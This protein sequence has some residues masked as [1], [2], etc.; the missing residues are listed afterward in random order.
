MRT[1]LN[2]DF[3][4]SKAFA[5]LLRDPVEELER[6]G[7]VCLE[8]LAILLGIPETLDDARCDD[9]VLYSLFN[10]LLQ[11][12]RVLDVRP[13]N[14][15]RASEVLGRPFIGVTT[16][17]RGESGHTFCTFRISSWPFRASSPSFR[18]FKSLQI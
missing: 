4:P 18:C 6:E 7:R 5:H 13:Q 15:D 10:L 1:Y 3:V 16:R 17:D 11:V 12:L 2:R 14:G 9:S 8:V